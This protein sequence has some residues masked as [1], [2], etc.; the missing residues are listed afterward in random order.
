MTRFAGSKL[1]TVEYAGADSALPNIRLSSLAQGVTPD[2]L[3]LSPQAPWV[4]HLQAKTALDMI[5]DTSSKNGHTTGL[6]GIWAGV[7]TM[8]LGGGATM[9]ARAAESIAVA[10]ESSIG[11]A[12]SQKEYEDKVFEFAADQY[13]LRTWR[14]HV[15]RQ[16]TLSGLFDA[17]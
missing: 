9:P 12:Y 11:V 5:L 4:D 2:R 7:P 3:V 14:A 16:R 15:E 1:V 17:R 13:K 6:D 8:V 10:L